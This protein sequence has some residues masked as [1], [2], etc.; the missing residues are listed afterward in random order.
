MNSTDHVGMSRRRWISI[1]TLIWTVV[2]AT[3]LIPVQLLVPLQLNTSDAADRWVAGVVHTGL[4][5]LVGG[6]STLLVG[7]AAGWISDRLPG[8]HRRRPVAFAG[9]LFTAVG[10]LGLAFVS[11]PIPVA[12]AWVVASAGFGTLSGALLALIADQLTR[13]ERGAASAAVSVAQAVGLIVGMGVIVTLDL[14]VRGGYLVLAVA[15]VVVVGTCAAVLPDPAPPVVAGSGTGVRGDMS[16]LRDAP[17]LW[18]LGSRLTINLGNALAVSLL[19]FFLMHGLRVA[20]AE[21]TLLLLTVVYVVA[22]IVTS[23]VTG[24]ATDRGS[25]RVPYVVTSAVVQALA[26]VLIV[27]GPTVPVTVVGGV[28][29]GVGYGMYST[30]GLALG[31]DLLPFPDA[32]GRDLAIV[33][34]VQT[35]PQLG[36]PMVGAL[37]VSATGDFT[38][39]FVA[40][41]ALSTLGAALTLPLRRGETR[42]RHGQSPSTLRR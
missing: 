42:R 28:L 14:G 4:V 10:L 17:F 41:A 8:G 36:G 37:L 23:A 25:R 16:S 26:A 32:H 40:S 3:Q 5:L 21:R 22:A 7:P 2:W 38:A 12:I 29:A 18:F 15:S 27:T 35:A 9:T 1:Y 33:N 19:L 20:D 30:A 39:L 11:S 13:G 31:T 24:I 6:I 34:A